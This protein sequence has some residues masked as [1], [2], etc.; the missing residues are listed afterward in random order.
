VAKEKGGIYFDR[1]KADL[2]GLSTVEQF[3]KRLWVCEAIYA[4]TIKRF[5]EK[6][7]EEAKA[8]VDD[9]TP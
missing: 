8:W 4:Y 5:I 9:E 3:T 6:F 7:P 2:D 1:L